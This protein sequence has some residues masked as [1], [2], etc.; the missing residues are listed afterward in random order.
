MADNKSKRLT[1]PASIK[2]WP[3]PEADQKQV[4]E[5]FDA[6]TAVIRRNWQEVPGDS[7]CRLAQLTLFILLPPRPVKRP[8]PFSPAK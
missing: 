3:T 5:V 1:R 8:N 6:L 2:N 7:R 4:G